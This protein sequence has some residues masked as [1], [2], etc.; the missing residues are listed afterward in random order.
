MFIALILFV[1]LTKE[2]ATTGQINVSQ[3]RLS[4]QRQSYK[5]RDIKLIRHVGR[6]ALGECVSVG[7]WHFIHAPE[8]PPSLDGCK[9]GEL[10]G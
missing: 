6:Q 5:Q 2:A 3:K 10:D 7:T 4:A 9:A 1:K 8:V